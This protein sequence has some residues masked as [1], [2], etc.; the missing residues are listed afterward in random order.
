MGKK[1]NKIVGIRPLEEA[2]ANGTAISK[3][4]IQKGNGE[5]K[6]QLVGTLTNYEIPFQKVPKEKIN[7]LHSGNHQGVVAF[8]APIPFYKLDQLLPNIFEKGQIPTIAILDG[9]T[10]VR[11]F[12]AIARSAEC[13]G[14]DALVIPHKG[15]A[16]IS[17]DAV[18][19]SA[20]ALLQVPV[21]REKNL[22]K[23]VNYVKMSGLK[24]FGISEKGNQAL[25]ASDFS[26]PSAII[27]GAE[28]EGLSKEMLNAV[29]ELVRIP[30]K[31]T[32]SS[33]NVSVSAGLVFYEMTR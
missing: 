32:I 25:D 17:E 9:I 29:D 5:G 1:Q 2:I 22:T 11:N 13:F 6:Q 18:S 19:A 31:G 10:D 12:G 14:I 15:S 21:C 30:L 27:L 28:G 4:F 16:T 26:G 8:V 24:V 33:L 23:V 7:R 3:V 20:G